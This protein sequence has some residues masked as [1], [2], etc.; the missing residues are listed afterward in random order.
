MARLAAALLCLAAFALAGCASSA[1]PS[2]RLAL[3][4]PPLP[5]VAE[6]EAT[7]LQ[8]FMDRGCMAGVGGMILYSRRD[9]VSCKGTMDRP[10]TDKGRLYLDLDCSDG[11]TLRVVLRNLGPD[12]GMGL[13]HI[14][15]EEDRLVLFYHPSEDEARRRLARLKADI[16]LAG[17][18]RRKKASSPESPAP[19]E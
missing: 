16:A 18:A 5:V 15:E 10:A 12:Q 14:G 3:D 19:A 11:R 7:A 8:G 1:A 4:G 2:I 13:G 6:G 17:E 9:N